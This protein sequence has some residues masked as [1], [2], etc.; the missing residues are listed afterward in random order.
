MSKVVTTSGYQ[1]FGFDFQM[2]GLTP[3]T[4]YWIDLAYATATAGDVA[5]VHGINATAD[6]VS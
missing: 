2:T 4:T 6:A 1:G 5:T 3:G